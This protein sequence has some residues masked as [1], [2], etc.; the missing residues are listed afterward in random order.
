MTITGFGGERIPH[1]IEAQQGDDRGLVKGV[2]DRGR[3][4][5]SWIDNIMAWTD[6]GSLVCYASHETE[7]TNPSAQPTVAK[8]RRRVDMIDMT[9]ASGSAASDA[10]VNVM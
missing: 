9:A 10:C 4:R 7:G 5:I 2:R 1:N 8:R 6:H 3:P